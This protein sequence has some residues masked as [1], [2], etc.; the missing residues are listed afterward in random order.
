MRNRSRSENR[1]E[2]QREPRRA[3]VVPVLRGVTDSLKEPLGTTHFHWALTENL[4][5]YTAPGEP[6]QKLLT[7]IV[8][9]FVAHAASAQCLN[10]PTP[11]SANAAARPGLELI[12]TAAAETRDAPMMRKTSAGTAGGAAL[13]QTAAGTHAKSQANDG[14]EQHRRPTGGMLLA[15][16]ALMSGIA[17]RRAGASGR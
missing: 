11:A 12:S 4:L 16:L 17:L 10:A 15:A 3:R 7:T 14:E 6:M 8:L 2:Q 9:C 13:R 1:N 5:H